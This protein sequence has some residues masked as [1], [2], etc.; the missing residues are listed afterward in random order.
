MNKNEGPSV[1]RY[2][3]DLEKM[4]ESGVQDK[5]WVNEDGIEVRMP[6]RMIREVTFSGV[7]QQEL[8][9]MEHAARLQYRLLLQDPIIKAWVNFVK[10][11]IIVIYNPKG[12]D[13]IREKMSLEELVGFLGKEGVHVDIANAAERDYDYY[14]EFYNYAFNPKVI[15]EH[16][17][18]GYTEEQWKRMKP[19]W[20]KKMAEGRKRKWLKFL[21][22]QKSY[23]KLHPEIYGQESAGQGN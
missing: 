19:E 13:N 11:R 3:Q 7:S 6:Y 23:E 20:E 16:A 14:K 8:A 2:K 21:D 15:R 22:Y 1:N 4:R 17:P 10:R 9:D 5:G 12:A 18:Y